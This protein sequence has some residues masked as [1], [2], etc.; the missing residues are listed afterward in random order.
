MGDGA[1]SVVA[2][3]HLNHVKKSCDIRV[4]ALTRTLSADDS[5][6]SR[7]VS[8]VDTSFLVCYPACRRQFFL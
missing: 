8:T 1:D 7:P 4:S 5:P 6:K 2:F 3:Q